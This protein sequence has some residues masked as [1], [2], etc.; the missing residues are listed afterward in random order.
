MLK[1]GKLSANPSIVKP[2]LT[3]DNMQQR[4]KFCVDHIN[5]KPQIFEYT[6]AVIHPNEKWLYLTLNNLKYYLGKE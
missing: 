3:E 4:I 6:M 2:T 1:G 5:I